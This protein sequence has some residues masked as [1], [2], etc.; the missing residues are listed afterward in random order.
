MEPGLTEVSAGPWGLTQASGVGLGEGPLGWSAGAA[1]PALLSLPHSRARPQPRPSPCPVSAGLPPATPDTWLASGGQVPTAYPAHGCTTPCPR[2]QGY[3]WLTGP[4]GCPF[5]AH[6]PLTTTKALDE[7]A[8]TRPPPTAS[9]S[10]QG[11]PGQAMHVS[12]SV[13]ARRSGA[14]SWPQGRLSCPRA[15]LDNR[16]KADLLSPLLCSRG[17]SLTTT[18]A[19]P[20]VLWPLWSLPGTSRSHQ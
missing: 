17:P 9:V 10:V 1:S 19:V 8:G 2:Q 12:A 16:P 3:R 18:Q 13:Q 4:S 20:R 7:M 5:K 14:R 6:P 11:R 15:S